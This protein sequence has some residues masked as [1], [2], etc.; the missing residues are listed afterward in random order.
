[1]NYAI[2]GCGM[3]IAGLSERLNKYGDVNLIGAFDPSREN[4]QRLLKNSGVKDGLIYESYEALLEDEKVDWVLI[5]SPN[6]VHR[7]QIVKSIK[8]GKHIFSEK[9]IATTIE[10][11]KIIKDVVDGSDRLFATGFTLRY[12]TIYREAKN[13]IA[14]GKL[15]EIVAINAS[16]NITPAHG[17]Y[18]MRN[19]RRKKAYAGPHVLEKCVHDLDILNWLTDSYPVR[20]QAIGGG[21]KFFCG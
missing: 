7:E 16:E 18:I 17:A 10:D 14:S 1:M 11:L 3:R 12:A 20:I 9:P 5:G 8:S 19:W 6:H 4:V 21:N 13:I 2:I 15:G